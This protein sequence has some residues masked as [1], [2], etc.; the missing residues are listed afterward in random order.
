MKKGSSL[1]LSAVWSLGQFKFKCWK[2]CVF[3]RLV[4]MYPDLMRGVSYI[5]DLF[6]SVL[7]GFFYFLLNARWSRF[8]ARGLFP[9]W[10]TM[11]VLGA[12][13]VVVD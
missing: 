11:G 3:L 5:L 10:V 7:F 4:S 9:G 12:G 6:G 8:L 2:T 13:L 1:W